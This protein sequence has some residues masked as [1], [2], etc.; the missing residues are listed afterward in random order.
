MMKKLILATTLLSL[1]I[2]SVA[3]DTVLKKDLDS[4]GKIDSVMIDENSRLVVTLSSQNFQPII[5][6]DEILAESPPTIS[7]ARVGFIYSDSSMRYGTDYHYAYDK[8]GKN[9]A[10][11]RLIGMDYWALGNAAN[12][13]S[14]KDSVNLLNGAYEGKW[15]HYDLHKQKLMPYPIIK[16]NIKSLPTIYLNDPT[17]NAKI[18]KIWQQIRNI[19]K[20]HGIVDN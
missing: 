11:I 15:H 20:Q 18:G 10:K 3:Q 9:R 17:K 7:D 19:N 4:D 6:Q 13:G 14:G 12:D 1:S 8:N 2:A 5:E 16:T